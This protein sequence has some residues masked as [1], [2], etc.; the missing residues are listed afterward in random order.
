MALLQNSQV[1]FPK[2]F[3]ISKP[4]T[5]NSLFLKL[6]LCPMFPSL[7]TSIPA[8]FPTLRRDPFSFVRCSC[9]FGSN[10]SAE[11]NISS[12]AKVFIKGL[13]LST[14][15][16]RLVKAFSEF[17]EVSQVKLL[18]DKESGQF[19]GIAYIWF[20]KEESAQLAVE[21]MNGKFFDGRF[22]DVRILKAGSS[23]NRRN[24]APY[25]F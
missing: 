15:G 4:S 2:C 17:G 25:K 14:S 10:S 24:T 1:V 11:F 5:P 3:A 18:M 8:L 16:G 6:S 22:I 19:L 21:K 23:K 20:A 7:S 12:P 9:N 13:P